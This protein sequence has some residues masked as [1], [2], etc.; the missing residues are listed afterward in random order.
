[1]TRSSIFLAAS[2]GLFVVTACS[3]TGQNKPVDPPVQEGSSEP[4]PASVLK[5][6]NDSDCVVV[7]TECCDHCNGGKALAFNKEGA[8]AHKPKNCDAKCTMM[9]CGEAVA[10]CKQS[11]CQVEVRPISAPPS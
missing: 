10:F 1:M 8:D 3:G 4:P 6:E 11:Q 7:E 5:C 9:A 2:L